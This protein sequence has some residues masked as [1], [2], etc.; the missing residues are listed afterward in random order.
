MELKET[1]LNGVYE[2]L[3]KP[4]IDERGSFTRIFDVKILEK[5][6]LP[7]IWVQENQS[8]NKKT[9]V[10]RG[11]HFLLSPYTDGKLIRCSKGSI[12]DVIVDIRKGSETYGKWVSFLLHE[13]DNR[14]VYIP[15]G[16]AHG[17]CSLTELSE[18][19]YKHDSYYTKTADSG[20]LWNDNDL[21]I[22][23][24]INN[25]IVSEKDQKLMTFIEFTNK[26]G[27]L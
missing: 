27:G 10:L 1:K 24:P 19:I 15:K 26:Y 11:L 9:G 25:P 4:F 12:Y 16:F 23:W 6:G 7:G 2:I 5:L 14:L 18:L 3:L 8:I 13:D 21:S 17:F 20:I 22:N